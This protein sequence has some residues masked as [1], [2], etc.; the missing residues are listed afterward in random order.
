MMC[1]ETVICPVLVR[2]SATVGYKHRS[3]SSVIVAL[4]AMSTTHYSIGLEACYRGSQTRQ[5]RKVVE[6][7]C[8]RDLLSFSWSQSACR[9]EGL[10][11]GLCVSYATISEGAQGGGTQR[12]IEI[13]VSVTHR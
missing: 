5:E 13:D 10:E 6:Q 11:V 12:A 8:V 3:A 4:R 2:R 1:L 7:A 9:F